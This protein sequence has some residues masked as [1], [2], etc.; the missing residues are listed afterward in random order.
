MEE[1]LWTNDKKKTVANKTANILDWLRFARMDARRDAIL[2]RHRE[3]FEWVYRD[4]PLQDGNDITF[5]RW[6]RECNGMHWIKGKA[7]SGKST[8]MKMISED[9]RT[10]ERLEAW[11]RGTKLLFAT[12]YFWFQ[13]TE[14]QKTQSGL[15][16]AVLYD[17]LKAERTLVP[18]AFPGW[19]EIFS[20]S[21]PILEELKPALSRVL[22]ATS[23]KG[24]KVCIFVDGLD[25]YKGSGIKMTDLADFLRSMSEAPN[26]KILVSSR[27]LQ[28]FEGAFTDL[29]QLSVYDL[30]GAD[31]WRVVTEN[32]E[33]HKRM[34][35]L[36]Q[37]N[38]D[39]ATKLVEEISQKSSGVFLWVRLA[40]KAIKEGFQNHESFDQLAERLSEL[41]TELDDMFAL[42]LQRIPG[43]YKQDTHMFLEVA[44]QFQSRAGNGQL[45]WIAFLFATESSKR[46]TF[47][48]PTADIQE[49]AL[50]VYMDELRVKL[51]TRT[52]GLLEEEQ[53]RVGFLH[54]SVFEFLHETSNWRD[55]LNSNSNGL[56][57]NMVIVEGMIIYFKTTDRTLRGLGDDLSNTLKIL[58]FAF[59]TSDNTRIKALDEIDR[60]MVARARS[61]NSAR[62][63][64]WPEYYCSPDSGSTKGGWKTT[65]L[66]FA[67]LCGCEYYVRH[68]LEASRIGPYRQR[69]GA[70]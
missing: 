32:L 23:L 5:S 25:E 46:S 47:D 38:A 11:S 52:F 60:T 41:P 29:P 31:I 27:P 13:G 69:K 14:M 9:Q 16:R 22:K 42:I 40:V 65:F 21:E 48:S 54:R 61:E 28:P 17:I 12:F 45:P 4:A 6:L 1:D 3:T 8:L 49:T 50:A 36:L 24:W 59:N 43:R 2:E 35:F 37:E 33:S 34:A 57:V 51:R 44:R 70:R 58:H 56:D 62:P 67:I 64:D 15:L 63:E 53:G 7:G 10:T 68:S 39:R 20:Q 30:T 18:I 55:L 19:Q 26:F 66:A